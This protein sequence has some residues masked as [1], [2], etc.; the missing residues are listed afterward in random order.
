MKKAMIGYQLYS[1][2]EECA[3]D[4]LGVLKQLKALGEVT[5]RYLICQLDQSFYALDFYKRLFTTS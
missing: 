3:K 5:E 1:A 2:R 4:L